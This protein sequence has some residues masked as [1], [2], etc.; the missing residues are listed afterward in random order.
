LLEKE[1]VKT[2]VQCNA[3]EGSTLSWFFVERER[4][5]REREKCEK[6]RHEK[7]DPTRER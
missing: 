7:K 6:T 1:E 3:G 2:E 5:T 4:W